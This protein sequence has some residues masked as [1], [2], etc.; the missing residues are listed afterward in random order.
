MT[1]GNKFQY[2]KPQR[3]ICHPA[4]NRGELQHPSAD[5][6]SED[7]PNANRQDANHQSEDRQPN[8]PRPDL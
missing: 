4:A 7:H 3:R 5:R 1:A 8:K 6:R 2:S